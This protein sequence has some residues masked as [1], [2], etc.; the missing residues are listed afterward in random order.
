MPP[1]DIHGESAGQLLVEICRLNRSRMHNRVEQLGLYHGQPQVLEN[2]W[3]EDGLTQREL[4]SRLQVRPATV[5]K[6]IQ[7]MEKAGF[8]ERR[9][10]DPNDE[11]LSR[12]YLTQ[13]GR[14]IQD[15]VR[16]MWEE[17][18]TQVYA[19]FSET[20]MATMGQWLTRVRDNLA[21]LGRSVKGHITPK[22]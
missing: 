13:S 7:R 2:L 16:A 4:A 6:T 3:Y 21:G 12:V 11:R 15:A 9:H 17:F 5:T 22:H 20:E 18:E 8:L 19:G 1:K 10:D 14:D